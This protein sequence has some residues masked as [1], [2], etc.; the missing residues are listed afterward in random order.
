MQPIGDREMLRVE[1]PTGER[2]PSEAVRVPVAYPQRAVRVLRHLSHHVVLESVLL[3]EARPAS[4]GEPQQA[5]VSARPHPP[6][7]IEQNRMEALAGLRVQRKELFE[8]HRSVVAGSGD[9][10]KQPAP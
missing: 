3:P 9:A 6:L 2:K 5:P 8:A 7:P 1:L 4:G 10:A